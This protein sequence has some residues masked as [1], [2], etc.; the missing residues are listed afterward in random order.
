MPENPGDIPI[1]SED[2]PMFNPLNAQFDIPTSIQAQSVAPEI[3]FRNV[4]LQELA[5]GHHLHEQTIEKLAVALTV[6]ISR[7]CASMCNVPLSPESRYIPYFL[8]FSFILQAVGPILS[9]SPFIL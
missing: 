2:I 8:L 6:R 7:G 5:Q 3:D 1:P 9:F 4:L